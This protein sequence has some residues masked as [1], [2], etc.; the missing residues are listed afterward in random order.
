MNSLFSILFKNIILLAIIVIS[1]VFVFTQFIGYNE[2]RYIFIGMGI[3][4]V[5]A[6]CYEAYTLSQIK[7]DTQKF[8]YFPDGLIAKRLIKIIAFTVFGVL[9][10]YS[11]S[12]I[13]Y[14]AFLC[15]LIAF[16]EIVVTLWRRAKHLCFVALEDDQLIIS[17]NKIHTT[18]AREIEKIEARHGLT[19]FI[20]YNRK[21]ITLRTD[22][23]KENKEFNS[24][25]DSWIVKNNL[26]DKVVTG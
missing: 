2:V 26:S 14:M 5:F 18:S 10:Y 13:R 12:I 20:N 21:A 24:A 25:L 4:Y 23:M 9:L 7:K 17:T 3:L 22:M 8:T 19:Y 16:T 15:F 1:L 11:G 6:A